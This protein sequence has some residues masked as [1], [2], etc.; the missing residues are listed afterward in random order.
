M[1]TSH[2]LTGDLSSILGLDTAR[3]IQQVL[4]DTNLGDVALVDLDN[5]VVRLSGSER[6]T[7]DSAGTFSVD[8]I[9]T[10]STGINVTD[11]SLRYRVSVQYKDARNVCN[12]DSGYFELTADADLSDK[13]G[14][15]VSIPVTPAPSASLLDAP[16]AANINNAASETSVALTAEIED[17]GA[18]FFVRARAV[19][20]RSAAGVDATGATDTTAALQ[21]AVDGAFAAGAPMVLPPGTYQISGL[22]LSPG[23][24]KDISLVG[25]GRDTVIKAAADTTPVLLIDGGLSNNQKQD[26]GNFRLDINGK[27]APMIVTEGFGQIGRLHDIVA[28]GMGATYTRG[29][30]ELG[31]DTDS[32]LTVAILDDIHIKGYST[33]VGAGIKFIGKPHSVRINNYRGVN[34]GYPIDSD[35]TTCTAGSDLRITGAVLEQC[36]VGM[37]LLLMQLLGLTVRDSRIEAASSIA[38]DLSGFDANYKMAALDLTGLYVSGM[39]S[40]STG[41][42]GRN[43]DA[44]KLLSHNYRAVNG[45]ASGTYPVGTPFDFNTTVTGI[46]SEGHN[47]DSATASGAVLIPRS[48]GT[49]STSGVLPSSNVMT[50]QVSLDLAPKDT[51]PQRLISGRYY[52]TRSGVPNTSALPAG[53]CTLSP[54]FIPGDVTIDRIGTE[55]TIAAATSVVRLGVYSCDAYGR[56]LTLV[57]DA[58]TVD[59]STTGEK[60]LT[61]SQSLPRGLYYLAAAVQTAG[62]TVRNIGFSEAPPVASTTFAGSAATTAPNCYTSS[63]VTG[64][65]PSTLSTSL[66]A[67]SGAT[68][69][70]VRIV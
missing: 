39:T 56:P 24:N 69:V 43:L 60:E 48:V 12:W 23:N 31:T 1:T 14:S 28:D 21:T 9:A 54:I 10:D 26:I 68:K 20:L 27:N 46:R 16:T 3:R 32:A 11:G 42:R 59:A 15:G 67:G 29:V 8:L 41:I 65:L 4:L 35:T 51:S 17:V 38:V 37:R 2:T 49:T 45:L 64:A 44:V 22:D 66:A 62:C 36:T 61:I 18:Q 7:I 63:S 34:I 70:R 25:M 19:D 5:N 33:T 47:N 30:I 53:F 52:G 13:A 55:V 40:G 58:G 57:L 50:D 6:I